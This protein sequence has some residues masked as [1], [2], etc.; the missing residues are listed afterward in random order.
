MTKI[1]SQEKVCS[2]CGKLFAYVPTG[3]V[4]NREWCS[5]C[6]EELFKG[7]YD[8]ISVEDVKAMEELKK[9]LKKNLDRQ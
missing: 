1:E 8:H 4:K 2:N 7:A 3:E 9:I 6:I 5:D